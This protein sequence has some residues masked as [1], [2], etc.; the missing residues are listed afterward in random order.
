[1]Q[2][3]TLLSSDSGFDNQ[4]GDRRD[5]AEFQEIRRNLEIPVVLIDLLSQE[6]ESFSRAK[7]SL[8]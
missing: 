2:A 7:E 8:I 4:I 3:P 1:V 6:V 5:V